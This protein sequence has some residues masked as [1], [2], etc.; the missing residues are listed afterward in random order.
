MK[1]T[2][3][4]QIFEVIN[5]ITAGALGVV[6]EMQTTPN[7]LSVVASKNPY[8]GRVTKRTRIA[9]CALGLSYANCVT[10]HA[11]RSGE[12]DAPYAPLAPKGM[13]YEGE[14][15]RYLASDKVVDMYYLNIL[16]R[17]NECVSNEF[18]LDG[19][20]VTDKQIEADIWAHIRVSTTPKRQIEYGVA[21]E[22]TIKV[23]R[24]KFENI[25]HISWGK[26]EYYRDRV[27]EF[28]KVEG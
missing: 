28:G 16:Y 7:W 8:L 22:D 10:A 20:V 21:E 4:E 1:K 2:M 15:R 12:V 14:N 26:I 18:L 17:G 13:H 9:N 19:E 11:E 25:T 24:P 6:V 23:N 27:V 3:N 5:N